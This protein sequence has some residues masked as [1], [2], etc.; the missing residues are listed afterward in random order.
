M[1]TEGNNHRLWSEAELR[2][3]FTKVYDD[4]SNPLSAFKPSAP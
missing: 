2:A 1:V 3:L 4:R